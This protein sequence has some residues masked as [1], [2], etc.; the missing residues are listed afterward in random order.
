[1]P[2]WQTQT[3]SICTEFSC[4][5][6]LEITG[7]YLWRAAG[8]G[9]DGAWDPILSYFLIWMQLPGM[10]LVD[11]SKYLVLGLPEPN[12][13]WSGRCGL[14]KTEDCLLSA[15][16]ARHVLLHLWLQFPQ[17]SWADEIHTWGN[18]PRV[19]FLFQGEM[20]LKFKSLDLFWGLL[21]FLFL[22][23][24][25]LLYTGITDPLGPHQLQ[26]SGK[27]TFALEQS[28]LGTYPGVLDVI[29]IYTALSLTTFKKQKQCFWLGGLKISW[30]QNQVGGPL[31][32]LGETVIFTLRSSQFQCVGI[33]NCVWHFFFFCNHKISWISSHWIM[34]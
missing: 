16:V 27:A 20:D 1:M 34:E 21:M 17:G 24:A 30:R 6:K 9:T 31:N 4:S 18:L 13:L 19:P 29:F 14:I 15:A 22:H 11:F 5:N 26:D 10:C 3:D 7:S 33:W 25:S 28:S 32:S 23:N 12:G 2:E 8:K